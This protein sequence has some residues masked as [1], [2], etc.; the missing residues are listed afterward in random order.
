MVSS[1]TSFYRD[2]VFYDG[3]PELMSTFLNNQDLLNDG[4]AYLPQYDYYIKDIMVH[5]GPDAEFIDIIITRKGYLRDILLVERKK[6]ITSLQ[7]EHQN[8]KPVLDALQGLFIKIESK[9]D[10]NYFELIEEELINV[11]SDI[12]ILFKDIEYHPVYQKL[13]NLNLSFSYFIS[14]NLPLSFFKRLYEITYD[15]DLIDDIEVSEE[16]FIDVFTSPIPKSQ[17]VFIKSNVVIAHYFKLIEPFFDNLSATKIEKSKCFLNKQGKP[18]K[19]GD[20]YTALSRGKDKNHTEK[21]RISDII[22]ELKDE[23]SN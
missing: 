1:L 9:K 17:I 2:L 15:L 3:L 5:D 11:V 16:A 14:K 10:K 8:I 23:Y 7:K 20:L 13:H 12:K 22:D 19:A 4:F 18:L 6:L 21:K